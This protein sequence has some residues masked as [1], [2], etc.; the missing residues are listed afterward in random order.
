MNAPSRITS[1]AAFLLAVFLTTGGVLAVDQPPQEP[2]QQ[3]AWLVGHL[4][5]DME[6]LGTFGGKAF[7]KVP[8]IVNRLTDDQ[9]ALLAQYYFLTRSKT[10]Q[11]AYLYAL[12]QQGRTEDQ[13]AEA[14]AAIAELLTAM[15]DEIVACYDQFITMP[16]PVQYLSQVCYSQRAGMVLQRPVLR[17]R[18]GTMTTAASSG[19][20]SMPPARALGRSRS[21]APTSMP[22][23]SSIRRTTASPCAVHVNRSINLRIAKRT[24][25]GTTGTGGA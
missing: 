25:S 22:A 13:V 16:Q 5:T 17:S 15:N 20:C 9:V 6:A 1:P 3:R 2:E 12:Q 24:G 11:D 21:A 19:R 4:V 23:A 10:E 7:A 8:R 18:R 14:K